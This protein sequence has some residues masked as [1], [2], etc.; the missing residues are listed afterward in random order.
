MDKAFLIEVRVCLI[1]FAEE[2]LDAQ[3][4][5][6]LPCVG[7]IGHLVSKVNLQGLVR[8]WHLIA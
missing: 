6:L 7:N 5:T 8:D 3:I 1:N 4:F 2:S